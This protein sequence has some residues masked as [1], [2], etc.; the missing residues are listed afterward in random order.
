MELALVAVAVAVVVAVVVAA[1]ARRKRG[2]L[3]PRLIHQTHDL[4]FEMLADPYKRN[5][6]RFL[7]DNPTFEYRYYSAAHVEDFIRARYG[8]TMLEVYRSIDPAY[9]PARADL[10]RYLL[11]YEEGGV[12]LDMK[13]GPTAPLDGTIRD[14]DEFLLSNWCEGACG[15]THWES[16]VHTGFGEYQQWWIACR[17]KH[18]FLRAV[19]DRCV[20]NIRGYAYDPN[21]RS[22]FGKLGVLVLTGPIAYTRAIRPLFAARARGCRLVP[23]SLGGA[24]QYNRIGFDHTTLYARHYSTLRTP[25][26]RRAVRDVKSSESPRCAP[27][28]TGAG[29]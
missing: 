18:P 16:F 22:T 27:D 9:G 15:R 6:R 28:G 1:V 25:I 4:P 17:P 20:R 19:I 12:Y 7:R 29:G 14:T 3:I 24:L 2:P 8:R 23:S 5:T 13:S 11:L 26:V 10:F 21:D